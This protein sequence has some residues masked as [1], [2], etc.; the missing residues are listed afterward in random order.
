MEETLKCLKVIATNFSSKQ[1]NIVNIWFINFDGSEIDKHCYVA[2]VKK[3]AA[4]IGI[5]G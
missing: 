3:D 2:N 4:P 1:I 5:V